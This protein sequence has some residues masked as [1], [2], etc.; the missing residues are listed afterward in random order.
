MMNDNLYKLLVNSD[1]KEEEITRLA[2]FRGLDFPIKE[3][4]IP[5]FLNTYFLKDSVPISET[6]NKTKSKKWIKGFG[7]KPLWGFKIN[8]LKLDPFVARYVNALNLIGAK[9]NSSCDGWH[10]EHRDYLYIEFLDRYSMLWHKINILPQ[11]ELHW[12]YIDNYIRLPLPKSDISKIRLYIKVN[13][14]AEYIETHSEKILKLKEIVV[15][16]LK[17]IKKSPL[18]NIEVEALLKE[19][20]VK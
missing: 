1:N 15:N 8:P 6:S 4:D 12:E 16:K 13:K 5:S 3:N 2:K 14:E 19:V 18:S 7:G 17:G 10:K 9:T 11:S 20:I